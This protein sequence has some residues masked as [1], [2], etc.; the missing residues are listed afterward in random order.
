MPRVEVGPNAMTGLGVISSYDGAAIVESGFLLYPEGISLSVAAAA[1]SVTPGVHRVVAIYEWTDANGQRHQSAPSNYVEATTVAGDRIAVRVPSLQLTQ[2]QG[3]SVG[4]FMTPVGSAT[5][6]RCSTN[7]GVIGSVLYNSGAFTY[8]TWTI[9]ESDA[10]LVKNEI[11]YTQPGFVGSML[12]NVAPPPITCLG[13]HQDRVFCDVADQPNTYRF[14]QR[15]SSG[16]GLQW[17]DRVDGSGK[18]LLG[19]SVEATAGGIVGWAP[20]DDKMI[21]FCANRIY[22]LFGTGP[23][24][25]G[26]YSQYSDPVPLPADVGCTTWRSIVKMPDGII[27]KSPKGWYQLGRDL[28][29]KYIGAPV[30]AYDSAIVYS[31]VLHDKQQECR[32]SVGSEGVTLVYSYI[33]GQWSITRYAPIAYSPAPGWP[34]PGAYSPIDAIIYPARSRVTGY[35]YIHCAP[36]CGVNGDWNAGYLDT[37]GGYSSGFQFPSMLI[38]TSFLR[39]GSINGF[40]RVRWLYLTMS[41]LAPGSP[42]SAAATLTLW[43]NDATAGDAG[44]DY[45][46][47]SFNLGTATATGTAN[48]VELRHKMLR[49]KCKSVSMQLSMTPSIEG[50]GPLGFQSMQLQVGVKRGTNK[51]PA[52]NSIG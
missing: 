8:V 13:V 51:L 5:F 40:Q 29:V 21:M 36:L 50:L 18:P 28:V 24:A 11:L 9:T 45:Y 7:N 38:Q 43:F 26:A 15:F 19:G 6:Y 39:L 47:T 3:V 1:A 37:Y 27:F 10:D 35:G 44:V 31:G 49:Q 25:S 52:A 33:G 48:T 34:P 22:A 23:D 14:S 2:R 30:K 32:W 46:S 41:Q 12:P 17:S 16:T 20:L 42:N 4:I